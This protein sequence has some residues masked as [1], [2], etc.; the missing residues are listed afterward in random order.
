MDHKL[1]DVTRYLE[2]DDYFYEIVAF[3][4]FADVLYSHENQSNLK[5]NIASLKVQTFEPPDTFH[6]FDQRF[7]RIFYENGFDM[8]SD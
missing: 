5:K 8:A 6:E 4:S 1:F 2:F 7:S 3:Q